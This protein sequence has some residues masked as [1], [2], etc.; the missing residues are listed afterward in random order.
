MD[1]TPPLMGYGIA[2]AQKFVEHPNT[3]NSWLTACPAAS[4]A[5]VQPLIVDQGDGGVL[6]VG[7]GLRCALPRL[8]EL[9][10]EADVGVGALDGGEVDDGIHAPT[11]GLAA[12]AAGGVMAGVVDPES[13]PMLRL[14][15]SLTS[16]RIGVQLSSSFWS[17][18]SRPS[19][20]RRR[21]DRCRRCCRRAAQEGQAGRGVER[22]KGFDVL[23][24]EEPRPHGV[25]P[26]RVTASWIRA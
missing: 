12:V 4:A 8:A 21:S 17:P 18:T 14:V 5:V 22:G 2:G 19:C 16:G 11:L 10:R 25:T 24:A 9:Q 13:A 23:L 26:S 20:C 15:N 6:E 3:L 1:G 7:A